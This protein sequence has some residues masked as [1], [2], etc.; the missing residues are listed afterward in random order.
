M[1]EPSKELHKGVSFGGKEAEQAVDLEQ[2]G[3]AHSARTIC[4]APV[5]D[6]ISLP[7]GRFFLCRKGDI[8][9]KRLCQPSLMPNV[10][11]CQSLLHKDCSRAIP[12]SAEVCSFCITTLNILFTHAQRHG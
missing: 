8:R 6:P 2:G 1:A 3:C 10:D 4:L 7:L 9:E 11:R 12:V 5:S